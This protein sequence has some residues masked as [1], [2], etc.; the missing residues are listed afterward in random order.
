MKKKI[1]STKTLGGTTVH[2]DEQG[3]TL[4][5]SYDNGSGTIIHFDANGK[6]SGSSVKVELFGVEHINHYDK[7]GKLVGQSAEG[8]LGTN[9]YDLKGNMVGK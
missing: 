8:L 2:T 5:S 1:Y 3:N 9:H 7:N 6:V 4:G